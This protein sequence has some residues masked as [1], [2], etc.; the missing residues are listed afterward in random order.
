MYWG[1][2][3]QTLFHC[4][5]RL[6]FRCLLW[7]LKHSVT[8]RAVRKVSLDIITNLKTHVYG[9]LCEDCKAGDGSAPQ[10]L[11]RTVTSPKWQTSRIVKSCRQNKQKDSLLRS[12]SHRRNSA[13]IRRSRL[14]VRSLHSSGL[15][16]RR[17]KIMQRLLSDPRSCMALVGVLG[18]LTIWTMN[19]SK[20]VHAAKL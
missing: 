10:Q 18:N 9:H 19:K 1:T 17:G 2:H 4:F 11:Q 20:S 16:F 3:L 7:N 8:G 12:V 14:W 15:S 5:L 6:R 13:T